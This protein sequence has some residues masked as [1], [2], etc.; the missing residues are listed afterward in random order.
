MRSANTVY[1]RLGSLHW[2]L[3]YY[4]KE[5]VHEEDS[6]RLDGAGVEEDRFRRSLETVAVEDRLDHDET[7]SE[8]LSVETASVERSLIRTVVEDLQEL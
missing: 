4:L 8:V 5:C 3:F 2:N 6:V 1:T 7:L